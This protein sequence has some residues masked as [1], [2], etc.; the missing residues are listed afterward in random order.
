MNGQ[1]SVVLVDFGGVLTS[2]LVE[3]FAELGRSWGTA[4][5]LPLHVLA[6]DPR[7]SALLVKHEEGAI[8]QEEFEEG[9]AASLAQRGVTV[10]PVGL[11]DRLQAFLRPDSA[12]LD[13]VAELRAQGRPVALV[14]NALGRDCYAGYDLPAL[15]DEIVVSSEVGIRKP[16]RRIYEIACERLQVEPTDAVMVDDL[17]HNLD[18]AARIGIAGIL[19]TDATR[20]RRG[21]EDLLSPPIQDHHTR[22]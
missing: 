2:S 15:F 17:R 13:L 6:T 12:M 4:P 19:H 8:E 18:G 9:Y 7:A 3:A 22:S 21:L 14:S 16:S 20:T 5:E 11:V 10:S 1:R